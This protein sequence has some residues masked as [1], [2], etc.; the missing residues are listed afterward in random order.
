MNPEANPKLEPR[1][2]SVKECGASV[3]LLPLAEGPI[4]VDLQ[5][6]E[7][8]TQDASG[9]RRVSGYRPHGA[10]CVDISARQAGSSS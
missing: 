10:T 3:Y 1:P 5:Q 7:V 8:I 9:Y 2:C 6:V 4:A